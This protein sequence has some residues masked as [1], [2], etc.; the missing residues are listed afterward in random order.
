MVSPKLCQRILKSMATNS[1]DIKPQDGWVEVV[2]AGTL[3]S[4]RISA[5]I[6]THPFFVYGGPTA[7][8]A[9]VNGIKVCH[10]PF[11]ITGTGITDGFWVRIK[12]PVPGSRDGNGS[13][14]VD[15]YTDGT[16]S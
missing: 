6:H 12:N 11:E 5:S 10:Y 1:F 15:V 8:A 9:T 2:T 3:S 16:I 7:P 13:L 14:R 4:V